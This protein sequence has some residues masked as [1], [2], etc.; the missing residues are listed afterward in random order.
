MEKG[1][2]ASVSGYRSLKKKKKNQDSY[3]IKYYR[4]HL[5]AVVCDGLGSKKHSKRASKKA[6]FVVYKLI[7][8]AL[9]KRH[10]DTERLTDSIKKR[11]MKSIKP[12]TPKTSDTTCSFVINNNKNIL[13]AQLGDGMIVISINDKL[14]MK[15]EPIKD[16]TNMTQSLGKS[17]YNDWQ[18]SVID[19][20]ESE[21]FKIMICTDGVS[22]DLYEDKIEDFV[23]AL[24]KLIISKKKNNNRNIK[25]ILK[26]W[27]NKHNLDDKT[28]VMVK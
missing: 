18:I 17:N 5:I 16:F 24:S 12:Y 8:I 2:G 26:E 23:N 21:H 14:Y 20:L 4:N 28:I 10:L 19:K 3:L 7:K 27:P 15:Q 13:L 25:S 22:E 6:C 1:Y 9:D 11:W